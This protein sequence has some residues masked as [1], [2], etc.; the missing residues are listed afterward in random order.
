M[1]DG[2]A[3]E[4]NNEPP[5]RPILARE[6]SESELAAYSGGAQQTIATLTRVLDHGIE[7]ELAQLVCEPE[8]LDHSGECEHDVCR[9]IYAL[10]FLQFNAHEAIREVSSREFR[11]EHPELADQLDEIDAPQWE[12]A[13]TS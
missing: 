13:L 1:N 9:L 6:L 10:N 4:L 8:A 11:A 12:P 5:E 7:P 2:E 3:S